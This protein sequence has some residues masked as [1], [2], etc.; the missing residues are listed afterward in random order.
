MGT[1]QL[2]RGDKDHVFSCGNGIAKL[3][4]H[5][6]ISRGYVCD[7]DC[8]R[9]NLLMER[10]DR[11]SR[12]KVSIHPVWLHFGVFDCWGQDVVEPLVK[13][14]FV[15]WLKNPASSVWV[16]LLSAV[17]VSTRVSLSVSG[18]ARLAECVA[19]P[20]WFDLAVPKVF[21]VIYAEILTRS[22]SASLLRKCDL[23]RRAR[24]V[25]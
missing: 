17:H 13:V 9:A 21:A 20:T 12:S 4:H 7:A 10:F 8:G 5:I 6:W 11:D 23:M 1:F 24:L 22:S 18:Y 15:K 3:L 14:A 25:F 16:T 19:I 2:W